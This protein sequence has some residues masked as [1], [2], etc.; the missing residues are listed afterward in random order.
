M[1]RTERIDQFEKLHPCEHWLP[2]V[3][4]QH[5]PNHNITP[6][7]ASSN[8]FMSATGK[9]SLLNNDIAQ[10]WEPFLH[11]IF[12]TTFKVSPKTAQLSCLQSCTIP[13]LRRFSGPKPNFWLV[14][15]LAPIAFQNEVASSKSA[16]KFDFANSRVR[17]SNKCFS[18]EP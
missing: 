11:N 13:T 10:S 9:G 7:G 12:N 2:N 5:T 8:C 1:S 15:G 17:A 16:F 3:I 18:K 4:S 14:L 6:L